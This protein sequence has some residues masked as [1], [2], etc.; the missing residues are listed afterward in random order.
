MPSAPDIDTDTRYPL[1]IPYQG[2]LM[3]LQQCCL[4]GPKCQ[5]LPISIPIPDTRCRYLAKCSFFHSS[6]CLFGS[7]SSS[8]SSLLP[9]NG[10][11]C[12]FI[13]CHFWTSEE[14]FRALDESREV[15]TLE[16]CGEKK[17][18]IQTWTK[19]WRWLNNSYGRDFEAPAC[20]L[21]T[22][23]SITWS[24]FSH[25]F[26]VFHLLFPM[27]EMLFTRPSTRGLSSYFD[28]FLA[29]LTTLLVI[30][31]AFRISLWLNCKYKMNVHSRTSKTRQGS[32]Q[33]Q[34]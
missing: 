23:P 5:L 14:T 15:P 19:S 2:F 10:S 29:H 3:L 22:A 20:L 9:R 21:L 1:S 26:H 11:S 13:L 7:F 8:S 34:W 28:S 25:H 27:W 30:L 33:R 6:I 32:L 31:G 17:E 12:C 16:D 4:T 24:K 18:S